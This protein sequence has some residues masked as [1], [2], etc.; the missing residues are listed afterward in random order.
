MNATAAL[1]QRDVLGTAEAPQNAE[2]AEGAEER[3]TWR[4]SDRLIWTK[5]VVARML[6][7]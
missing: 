5:V 4:N 7:R 3:R 6:W 1:F 2:F